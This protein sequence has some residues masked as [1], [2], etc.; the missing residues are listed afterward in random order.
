MIRAILNDTKTQTRRIFKFRETGKPPLS[1]DNFNPQHVSQPCPYGRVGDRL[2]VRETWNLSSNT[3]GH[4]CLFYRADGEDYDQYS[5]MMRLWDSAAKAWKIAPT[6]T[7]TVPPETWKPAI[8]MPRWAS[9]ITLEITGVKVERLQDITYDDVMA[10]GCPPEREDAPYP[11]PND[12]G[13]WFGPSRWFRDLWETINGPGSW[14]A[15]PWVWA[16]EFRRMKGGAS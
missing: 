3:H 13:S 7:P 14:D 6:E 5:Q 16:I 1:P 8:H 15:N 2:W 12:P 11:D 9:R 10:E 4:E